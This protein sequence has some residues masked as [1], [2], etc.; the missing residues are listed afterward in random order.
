MPDKGV[1]ED[2]TKT[3]G[4]QRVIKVSD[5]VINLLTEYKDWQDERQQ[6]VGSKWG[7]AQNQRL[8]KTAFGKPI[9]PDTITGWFH[10][11]IEKKG[12]PSISIHSLRH[13]NWDTLTW[14]QLYINT[15]HNLKR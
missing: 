15:S 12:L 11:F 8:F 2:T 7:C 6:E 10:D 3:A 5:D 9:F 4:S 14:L 13:T 1:F